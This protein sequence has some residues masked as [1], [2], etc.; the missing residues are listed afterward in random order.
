MSVNTGVAV[1]LFEHLSVYASQLDVSPYEPHGIIR[2]G[3]K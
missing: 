1:S 3:V 2:G